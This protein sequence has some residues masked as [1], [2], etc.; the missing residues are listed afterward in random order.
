MVEM[1]NHAPRGA[2]Q[3]FVGRDR[4]VADLVAGLED[5]IA[6]RVRLLVIT[7]EPGIGK[8]WLAEHLAEH[9]TKRGARVLWVR[10][11]EAGGAPPFW[12]WT[13][14]L[15]I[16]AEG[17]DDQT[18]ATWLGAGAAQVA[19]L[20][21]E[22]GERLGTTGRPPAPARAS[23]VARLWLF[24]AVTGFLRQAAAAQP[25]LLVLEDLQAADASSLL[26]LEFLARDLR[27][28]RLLLLGTYRNLAADRVHGIGDA[29]GQLVHDGH[30]LTLRGLNRR[31]V[32]DLVEAL[33][34]AEPSEAMVTAVHEATEG[35]PLFVRE[36][37]RLLATD[38][39]LEDPGRLRVPLSGSVRTVIGRRLAPLSADAVLVLSAAA[40]VGREF[41]LSL[42]GAA[43]ELPIE[44][45]LDGLSEAVA[46]DVVAETE[47]AGRY[48]FSH[49]LI[50]EVLYERLPIP[51]RMDLHRRVGEAIERQHGGGPGA[52]VAELAYHFGEAA[53]AGAA[54]K[55]LVYA[56]QA[57]ERAMALH[58]YEEAADQYRRALQAL[59]FAGPDEPVR[60]ELLLRLGAA[61]ARAGR[62]REAEQSC[63]EAAE[64]SR[65]L[66]SSER[67]AHAALALGAQELRGEAANRPL[68]ALLRE[69]LEE[70][71][72]AD[73]P[74]RARLLARLSLELTLS[75]EA[76][77]AEPTSREAVEVARRL[78]EAAT[79]GTALRAR[80]MTVWG[81]DGLEERSAI[82]GEL[83]GLARAAGDR[84]L[85]L[86]GR[87]LRATSSLQS[88]DIREVEADVAA[89]ARLADELQLPAHR[90]TATTM[91]AM[92]AQLRG[93]LDE[94]ETLAEQ[95]RSLQPDAPSTRFAYHD[96]IELLCWD[97]DRLE[98]LRPAWR[99]QMAQTPWL[100][101]PRLW[102]SLSDADLG[103]EVTARGTLQSVVAELTR[104]RRDGP[105]P[106]AMAVAALVAA[107]LHEPEAA[108]RLYRALLPYRTQVIVAALLHPVVCFG[109]VS[110]YLGLLAT[111]TPSWAEAAEHFEAALAA[112]DRLGAG[113]LLARTQCQYARMLLARGRAGDRGRAL[114]LLDQAL[115]TAGRHG[116]AAVAEEVRALQS[117]A[118]APGAEGAPPAAAGNLFR[119]EGEY[120]TVRYDGVVVRLK[121]AKGLHHLARLLTHPGR[122][123]HAIDLEAAAGQPAPAAPTGPRRHSGDGE[124]E[125]RPDLGDAGELL[126]ATAKAAYKARLDELQGE[127]QE[128]E[129]FNDPA[130]AAKARAELDFLVGELARAVGLGGRDRRAASHAERARLNVTRA[131]RTAMANLARAHPAFGRHLS[132]TIRTGRYCS[133][134]PDP[135]VPITWE[136]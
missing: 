107:R 22:L 65:R 74:L 121:D 7:G 46:L 3:V 124:L 98:E 41:D 54:A 87:S 57:G 49:A 47:S 113:P 116:L 21:P 63:L 62:R 135:R 129:A 34:G 51:V 19:Q 132:S 69:A 130:R 114:R 31:E 59:R 5:A 55:A 134:I 88:G 48:R 8:T 127:L 125:L 56:R 122:E 29:M 83:L 32:R 9:A 86:A 110:F 112:H 27:G 66:G 45:I 2:E 103:E 119:R 97:Q 16:L 58:A 128:A 18:L 115:A 133:Y 38:V 79:L 53:A 101:W 13:Q 25:L 80:W 71:P 90:W 61:Q 91:R 35:N 92:L 26:L 77:L 4:E 42:V 70:L 60:C 20:V 100:V 102:L 117:E 67:L 40:V 106:P 108:D 89:C 131:I 14:L 118:G 24:E 6:G 52:H 23:E 1:G 39:T 43:C 78:G 50:R 85:E 95:A 82:A 28:G 12:P 105:W 73:S 15:R 44:R 123:F 17:V 81:P 126:D 120:W 96:L 99:E 76:G 37:V 64:L 10:C 136:R 75:D 111:V 93:S 72:V 11:W 84:E 68:I 94:A 33:S 36:T 109:S 104:R 30:L